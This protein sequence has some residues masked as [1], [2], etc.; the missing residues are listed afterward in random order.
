MADPAGADGS[1][2]CFL[3]AVGPVGHWILMGFLPLHVWFL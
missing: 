3:E 1:I 2:Y